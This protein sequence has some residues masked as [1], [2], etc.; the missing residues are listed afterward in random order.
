MRLAV[1]A[2]ALACAA[3]V[4]GCG[5]GSKPSGAAGARATV[6]RYFAAVAGQR[7]DAAC[8]QLTDKSRERLAEFARPLQAGGGGCAATMRAVLSS[9]YGKRLARFAHPKI[10]ALS[11][12]GTKASASVD[13]VAKPLS[14]VSEG[15]AWHIDF[16]PSV[17]ADKLP[18]G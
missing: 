5:G 7:P 9:A 3:A 4:S 8:A 17:E 10:T 15:G 2:A 18:G 14:L 12:S 6:Q 13:G 1:P 16:V 11:V